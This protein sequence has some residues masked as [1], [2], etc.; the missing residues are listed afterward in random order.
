MV[1][2]NSLSVVLV[3]DDKLFTTALRHHLSRSFNASS[4]QTFTT[5]EQCLKDLKDKPDILLLDYF[6]NSNTSGAMDGLQVLKWMTKISPST[7]VIMLSSQDKIEVALDAMKHGA[8]EYIV[9]DDNV[10]L[11]T[12]LVIMNAVGAEP[13]F[14]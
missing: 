11:Q 13:T 4:I 5:G 10:F 12:K 8:Y 9:K 6:L 2:S 14:W 3:D 1:T 7:K